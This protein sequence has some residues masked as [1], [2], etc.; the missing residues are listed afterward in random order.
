MKKKYIDSTFLRCTLFS[1]RKWI[2][3]IWALANHITKGSRK[4]PNKLQKLN[5]SWLAQLH[6]VIHCHTSI[7]EALLP[8]N[9]LLVIWEN[10]RGYLV[11]E[12]L[13]PHGWPCRSSLFLTS[14]WLSSR[15]CSHLGR[16]P[17]DRR[18]LSFFLSLS[19][20]LFVNMLL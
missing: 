13:V 11:P 12:S 9:S 19:F 4:F 16:E 2:I 15:H 3:L 8:P 6:L 20:H 1:M 18:R 7:P 10:H 14:D 5:R 17:T